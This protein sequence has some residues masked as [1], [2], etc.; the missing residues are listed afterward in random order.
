[1]TQSAYQCK[2][3]GDTF[4]VM[5]NLNK[6]YDI[7]FKNLIATTE[8]EIAM[9]EHIKQLEQTIEEYRLKEFKMINRLNEYE[10]IIQ[11]IDLENRNFIN[12]VQLIEYNSN[13][14]PTNKKYQANDV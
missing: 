8:K 2:A 1:M 7:L 3:N 13:K 6:T 5:S 9:K 4:K 12:T 11:S 14:N 10:K